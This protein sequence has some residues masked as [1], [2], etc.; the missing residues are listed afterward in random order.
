[1]KAQ[2][3]G[4]NQISKGFGVAKVT[5]DLGRAWTAFP[6][7]YAVSIHQPTCNDSLAVRVSAAFE[8]KWT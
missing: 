6:M 7:Q 3:C 4:G 1:M 8:E 2:V 5:V